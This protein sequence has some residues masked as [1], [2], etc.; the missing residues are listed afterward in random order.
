MSNTMFNIHKFY[1]VPTLCV[2]VLCGF[3]NSDYFNNYFLRRI[4]SLDFKTATAFKVRY[5]HSTA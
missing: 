1:V 5:E 2:C 4:N 3:Q